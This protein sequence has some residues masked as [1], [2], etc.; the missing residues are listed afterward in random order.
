[1]HT[2]AKSDPRHYLP[3]LQKSLWF[4]NLPPT[5]KRTCSA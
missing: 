3:A 5:D 1:M 2:L 4:A